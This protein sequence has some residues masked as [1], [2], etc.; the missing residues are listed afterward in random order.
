[1]IT[2]TTDGS[3]M[4]MAQVPAGPTVIDIVESTLPPG[5]EQ[6]AGVDPTTVI[7]PAGGTATDIDG[8]KYPVPP[9]PAPPTNAP[10][11]RAPPTSGP[12]P[13][14]TS[15]QEP[16]PGGAEP[17][18]ATPTSGQEPTPGGSE[19]T[20]ATPTGATPTQA[21]PTPSAPTP[22]ECINAMINFNDLPDGTKLN[23]GE[24]LD[25]QY[26]PFYGLEFSSSGGLRDIPRLFDTAK[27]G[28]NTYGDPDLGS[29]NRK[30]PG[31]GPGKGKG[32]EPGPDGDNPYQNCEYLGNVLIIQEDNGFEEQP[33]DNQDGGTVTMDFSPMAEEVYEIG[34]LDVDYPVSITIVYI[35]DEGNMQEK[36][37]ID[38]PVRGNNSNQTVVLNEKN[39]VQLRLN[40]KR[41]GATT[42]L[43]F[44]YTPPGPAPTPSIPAPTPSGGQE[45]TPG[46]SPTPSGGQEPTPGTS[47]TPS[48]GQEPTPGTSPTPSGGQEPTPGGVPEPTP[49]SPTGTQPTPASPTGIAPTQAPPPTPSRRNMYR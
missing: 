22:S 41:S 43:S 14:P 20:P 42:F 9:T 44:C 18:P 46:T 11:T 21:P 3:G 25:V 37:P 4:Y 24:Y 16:T 38:V 28:N 12:Q 40:L 13:T 15:G 48:G 47:P 2:V 7:V 35:D 49:P 8:Y 39:V 45:P 30:C 1:M 23:G 36:P 17:T 31:G 27:V 34:M 33:D 6:T 29:P 10:P 19:P 5:G 26:K 32:G